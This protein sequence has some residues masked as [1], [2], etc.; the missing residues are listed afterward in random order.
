MTSVLPV[1]NQNQC[2][3]TSDGPQKNQPCVFPF[4]LGQDLVYNECE[5]FDGLDAPVCSTKVDENGF[6]VQEEGCQ[7]EEC[8]YWGYCGPNCPMATKGN[9]IKDDNI[10]AC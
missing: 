2:L 7:S 1:E 5:W 3:T 9:E 4:K 8:T 6:H 10:T